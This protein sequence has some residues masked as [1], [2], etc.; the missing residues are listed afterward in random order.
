MGTAF[1]LLF[2]PVDILRPDTWPIPEA[3]SREKKWLAWEIGDLLGVNASTVR[4]WQLMY[5]LP[6]LTPQEGSRLG[7][8]KAGNDEKPSRGN[9]RTWAW[10][11][12]LQRRRAAEA[13]A[14]PMRASIE[15]R[16][17]NNQIAGRSQR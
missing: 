16:G 12:E 4:N 14:A 17:V 1:F 13:K 7:K 3:A 2:C 11:D 15:N 9:C 6:R 8:Q 5:D 10:F